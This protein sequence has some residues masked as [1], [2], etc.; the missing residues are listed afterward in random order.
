[1]TRVSSD[2]V[3]IAAEHQEPA[4]VLSQLGNTG[5]PQISGSKSVQ[6]MSHYT[7]YFH[8]CVN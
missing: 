5:T 6:N 7:F 2:N 8:I 3:N 1:M 4:E